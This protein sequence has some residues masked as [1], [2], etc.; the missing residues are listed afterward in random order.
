[1]L[2]ISF[3]ATHV[4][5]QNLIPNPS[6]EQYSL[7]PQERNDGIMPDNWMQPTS[8]TSDYFNV[9]APV[10]NNIE[11]VSIPNNYFGNQT[12]RTGNAYAGLYFSVATQGID[13]GYREYIQIQLPGRLYAGMK[14]DFEMYVSLAEASNY[15]GNNL[16]IYFSA[17]K[18]AQSSNTVLNVVPQITAPG[19]ITDKNSWTKIS[20]KLIAQGGEQ[21]IT[22]G[23]FN[24]NNSNFIQQVPLTN[25]FTQAPNR[26]VC[27]YYIDDVSLTPDC[28][29]FANTPNQTIDTCAYTNTPI[30]LTPTF[31]NGLS[32]RW[33]TGSINS[34]I[35]PSVSGI[36]SAS[37]QVGHCLVLDTITLI[38]RIYPSSNLINDTAICSNALYPINIG[39]SQIP[40]QTYVWNTGE[41]T[42]SI[43]VAAPGAYKIT[44]TENNCSASDSVLVR[45]KLPPTI[46]LPASANVC[47]NAKYSANVTTSNA[48][49][50]WSTGSFS[51]I[52]QLLQGR[53]WVNVTVNGCTTSDTITITSNPNPNLNLGIDTSIC[54]YQQHTISAIASNAD[55][56]LWQNGSIAPTLTHTGPGVFWVEIEKLGCTYRD[57]IT[58]LGRTLPSVNLGADKITCPTI[59]TTL[60]AQTTDANLYLWNT[61][62]STQSITT[63]NAGF[64]WLMVTSTD[65][66]YAADT[67]KLD[68]FATPFV[69]IGPDNSFCD[70]TSY[71]ITPDKPFANY[72]WQDGSSNATFSA[73]QSGTYFLL[74]TDNNGCNAYDTIVLN[75]I[76]KPRIIS[77]SLVSV[78][79]KDTLLKIAGSFRSILWQNGDTTLTYLATQPG[80][81][82]VNVIDSNNCAN[83]LSILV[84]S[85]C[86]ASIY[87]PTAFSP[88]NDGS[89]D[90]FFA[91]ASDVIRYELKIYSRWGMLVFE[92]TDSTQKWDGKVN[93]ELAQ[94]DVYV[95]V[96]NYT[97]ANKISGTL[98]G[99][100]TLIR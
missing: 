28:S 91:V 25:G 98:S 93:G 3:L 52:E 42:N 84:E 63:N 30:T 46:V 66:C 40:T 94:D 51:P 38:K 18:I 47:F 4:H 67:L 19:Y 50:L 7:C 1:M 13:A 60:T 26:R 33:N 81:Y 35:S 79:R 85:N 68:T 96:I 92:T 17:N 41:T 69:N 57:T 8:G 2:I 24:T 80:I 74:A 62:A 14:Y 55:K 83:E 20:A 22:I 12:A 71:L 58:I 6:F 9:C 64:Y 59:E 10:R 49:Y 76:N 86:P 78:C 56:Y 99:Q 23:C 16:G 75:T 27:Y 37:I 89:N 32:Y 34:T 31:T 5:A 39:V 15:A 44:I 61:G 45:Q 82:T 21:F 97:G 90:L 29:D 53:Y 70:G 54:A 77:N 88:N 100:V 72:T 11:V 95:Y 65:G 48:S 36:Y 73:T 43:W 87:V